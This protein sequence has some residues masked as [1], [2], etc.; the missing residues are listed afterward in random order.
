MSVCRWRSWRVRLLPDSTSAFEKSFDVSVGAIVQVSTMRGRYRCKSG[1]PGGTRV[2]AA[3][4]I[5]IGGPCHPNAMDDSDVSTQNPR[6]ASRLRLRRE[7]CLPR[8]LADPV[9]TL[10]IPPSWL[11]SIAAD[12]VRMVTRPV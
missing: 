5:R 7:G 8:R 1:E 10:I 9:I 3:V 11:K 4:T 6:S 12:C 2:V